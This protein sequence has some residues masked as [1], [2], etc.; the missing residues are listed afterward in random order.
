MPRDIERTCIASRVVLPVSQ[1]VRFV[2]SPEGDVVFDLK[3]NLP[4]RGVWV[5]RKFSKVQAVLEKKLFLKAF[6]REVHASPDLG[7]ILGHALRRE[8]CQSLAL[9]NKAGMVISGFSKVEAA[10][11]SKPLSAILH[12]AEAADDGRKKVAS[13]LVK[14]FGIEIP[15]PVIDVLSGLELDHLFGKPHVVHAVVLAG[16]GSKGFLNSWY[17]FQEY[18]DTPENN[19]QRT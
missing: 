19:F 18:H 2:L 16:L 7:I 15:I 8:M 10:I 1:M 4:G 5:E 3:H 13:L 11:L 9:A 6:K 14:R 12:A 17:Q